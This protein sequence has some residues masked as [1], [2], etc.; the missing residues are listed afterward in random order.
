MF[1]LIKFWRREGI[2]ICIYIDD[3]LGTSPSL[4]LALEEAEFVR[5][6]LTRFGFTIN[7]EKPVWQ[8]Q[9]EL[10]CLGINII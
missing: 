3:S 4:D 2:K 1:S 10:I 7:S 8:P 6:S 5:N 9:Q